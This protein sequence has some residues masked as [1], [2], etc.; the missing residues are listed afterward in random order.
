MIVVTLTK[1]P[2]SLR[3]DLTK[4]FQEIQTGVYVG[5]VSARV[6]DKLWDRIIRDIGHGEATMVFNAQNEFGYQFRTTR[7][8]REVVDFDG[9]PLMKRLNSVRAPV[10]HGF[11]TAAKYHKARMYSKIRSQPNQNKLNDSF[12]SIDIETTG[13]DVIHDKIVSVGAVK[14]SINGEFQQFNAY[15]KIDDSM[16]PKI[17]K[18]T[19]ITNEKLNHEGRNLSEVLNELTKFVGDDVIVGYNSSFDDEFISANLRRLGQPI[20]TNRLVDLLPIVKKHNKFLDNFK[21]STI[22]GEYEIVN[23]HPHDALSD[24][25][26]TMRL[27]EELIK[28]GQLVI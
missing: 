11:S 10:K 3:G 25:S 6:R 14:R 8:D 28:K 20:L 26:A 21:L 7:K 17:S 22:L 13:L 1:V 19:G 5:T 16:P 18:L 9:I 12:A 27:A 24:A 23:S 15:V 2:P 4:W